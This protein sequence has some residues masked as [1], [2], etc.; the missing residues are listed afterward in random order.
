MARLERI[1]TLIM[2]CVLALT[3]CAPFQSHDH[4]AAV[5]NELNSKIIFSGATSNTRDAEIQ[6]AQRPLAQRSY[7]VNCQNS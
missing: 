5:C 6:N 2:P 4:R 3:A 1:L 7:D